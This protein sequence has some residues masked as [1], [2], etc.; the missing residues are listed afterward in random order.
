V[1]GGQPHRDSDLV[2]DLG[3][4]KWTARRP[5]GEVGRPSN[6]VVQNAQLKNRL[7]EVVAHPSSNTTSALGCSALPIGA[8]VAP[9]SLLTE[10]GAKLPHQMFR[11]IGERYNPRMQQMIDR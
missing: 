3:P 7:V 8:C 5:N 11:I 2:G 9:H 10:V 4:R 6:R 1:E